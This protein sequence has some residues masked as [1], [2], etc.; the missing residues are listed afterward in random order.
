MHKIRTEFKPFHVVNLTLNLVGGDRL[1]WQQRRAEPQTVSPLHCGTARLGYRESASYGGKDGISLGTAVAISGAAANPNMGYSSSP[2]IGFILTLFNLRLGAWLGNPGD[3]G[4][5]TWTHEGPRS[6]VNSLV[7]EAFGLTNDDSPYVNLSDGGHFENLAIYEMVRRRCR[8]IVVLDGGCD[9][10][11]GYEDLG[12]A[13][14]KIRIDMKIPIEFHQDICPPSGG[15]MRRCATATIRY[16]AVDGEGTD[17]QLIYIKPM[18]LGDEP[19]DVLSYH[20]A[21][22]TFPHE[23]TADQWFDESQ[24]ESYRTLGQHTVDEILKGWDGKSNVWGLNPFVE[25]GYLAESPG[26]ALTKARG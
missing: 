1:A 5:R 10:D 26:V 18:V 6:A 3:A 16:S 19:P 24:T 23:S 2:V 20:T 17:G 21:H 11:F 8:S 12:N 9:P 22:P 4:N 7:R 13:L 14:R 15:T 25:G